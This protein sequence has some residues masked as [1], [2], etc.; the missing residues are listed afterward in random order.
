MNLAPFI[1]SEEDSAMIRSVWPEG[2]PADPDSWTNESVR[3]LRSSIKSHY[4]AA[5]NSKC[6]YC[7]RHLGSENR[8]IWDV[9]HVVPR[10]THPRFMFEPRNL[11]AS[12]PDCNIAKRDARVLENNSRKTYPTTS[13]AFIILHPHFDRFADH[14]YNDGYV[15]VPKT[16]KGKRTIYICDLLRF[17]Q[18]YIDWSTPLSDARFEAEVEEVVQ[19]GPEASAMLERL[20]KSLAR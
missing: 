3:T 17:A 8:R 13:Q 4:I 18:K 1:Y 12:C 7:D 10:A 14:I 20:A 15:Y 11:A 2:S 5:Q 9:D 6:C 19:D 16:E